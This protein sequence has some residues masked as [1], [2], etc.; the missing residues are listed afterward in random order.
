MFK[1]YLGLTKPGIIFGNL[2]AGSAGFFMAAKGDIEWMLFLVTMLGI[3]LIIASGCVF[4]NFIDR[5]IDCLMQRTQNRVLVKK[6]VPINFALVYASILGLAGFGLLLEYTNLLTFGLGVLGFVVYVGLYSMYFK[7]KSVYGT[8]IGSL[9]G[10]CPPVIGY[11]A[12]SNQFD[13]GALI[14]LAI[15]CL[16]QIPHSYAIAIYRFNDYK[17][18]K[19]P[20]LPVTD[21]IKAA[22]NHIIAYIIAF[23]IV[24][25][26]LTQQNHMGMFYAVAVSALGLYWLYIAVAKYSE[27]DQ[28]QWGK[29]LF[30]FSI[31][32]ITCFSILIS[33][34]FV[35]VIPMLAS[36]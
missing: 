13:S 1:H 35:R 23:V 2:I 6:L 27:T 5:D 32:T 14:L 16:W 10:A 33:V 4:N 7:R 8:V 34:D 15:F 12:A 19:I 11:C 30:V 17:A 24:A 29:D 9:S 28:Q 18:A 22:R 25:L 3:T 26:L 21:G 36:L 31:V 20:V